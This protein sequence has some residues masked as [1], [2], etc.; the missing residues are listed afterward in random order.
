MNLLWKLGDSNLSAGI[1][2]GE[3]VIT[4]EM[5]R[6]GYSEKEILKVLGGNFMRVFE[7]AE[8]IAKLNSRKVSGDGSLRKIK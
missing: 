5:L 2:F 8:T 1:H 7:K 6:R 3:H 4:Y